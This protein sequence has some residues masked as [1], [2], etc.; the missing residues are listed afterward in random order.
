MVRSRISPSPTLLVSPSVRNMA[1]GPHIVL[2]GS[3]TPGSLYP[4]LAVA[5][6]IAERMPEATITFVGSGGL[7]L[8]SR[9]FAARA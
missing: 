6:H 1:R 5:A 3:G 2:A 8:R 7:Q 9:A 4:G